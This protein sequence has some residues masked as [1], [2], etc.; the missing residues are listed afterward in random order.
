M[1][2]HTPKVENGVVDIDHYQ[3]AVDGERTSTGA[4]HYIIDIKTKM[5]VGQYGLQRQDPHHIR[6]NG[7]SQGTIHSENDIPT[8]VRG[9]FFNGETGRANG[10]PSWGKI[11]MFKS[12]EDCIKECQKIING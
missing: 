3:D 7:F 9:E 10:R 11:C 1:T 5:M 4:G 2:G 6:I 8:Q 12:R